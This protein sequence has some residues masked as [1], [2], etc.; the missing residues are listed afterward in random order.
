MWQNNNNNNNN[1]N[2]KNSCV[3]AGV[4]SPK[5]GILYSKKQHK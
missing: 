3:F 5:H 4:F 2:V 1:N